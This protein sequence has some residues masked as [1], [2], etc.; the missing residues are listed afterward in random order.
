MNVDEAAA[1]LDLTS[2]AIRKRIKMGQIAAVKVKG[3]WRIEQEN[4]A[5]ASP[6]RAGR[7]RK[8]LQRD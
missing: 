4:L 1:K 5:N 7:P 8:N 3:S 6:V 2:A